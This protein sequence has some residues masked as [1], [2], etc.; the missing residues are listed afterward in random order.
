[1]EVEDKK[2]TTAIIN[3]KNKI[4]TKNKKLK[5]AKNRLKT[6]L[7]CTRKRETEERIV[8][9]NKE[10]KELEKELGE[11]KLT[12]VEEIKSKHMLA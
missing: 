10:L 9:L 2:D 1:M 4:E 8:N 11:Q 5:V 6:K 3:I 7:S 12:E